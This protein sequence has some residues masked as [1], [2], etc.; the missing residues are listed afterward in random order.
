MH[1]ADRVRP[2]SLNKVISILTIVAVSAFGSF[3]VLHQSP[4]PAAESIEVPLTQ[5]LDDLERGDVKQKRA[6]MR[7]L[8]LRSHSTVEF[9]EAVRALIRAL[10]D[11]SEDVRADATSSLG[12]LVDIRSLEASATHEPPALVVSLSPEVEEALVPL[13][14]APSPKFRA[15]AA[16]SLEQLAVAARLDAPPPG[17]LDRYLSDDDTATRIAAAN[18]FVEFGRGPELLLPVVLIRT[19]EDPEVV[20]AA[21]AAIERVRL[22]PSTVPQ[23]TR[24]LAGDDARLC[25]MCASSLEHIGPAAESALTSL[26]ALI[27]KEMIAPRVDENLIRRQILSVAMSAVAKIKPDGGPLGDEALLLVCNIL[28]TAIEDDRDSY[29]LSSLNYPGWSPVESDFHLASKW[30]WPLQASV[31]LQTLKELRRPSPAAV[32]TLLEI[33]DVRV[34]EAELLRTDLAASLFVISRGTPHQGRADESLVKAWRNTN[35]A[36]H[37]LANELRRLGPEAERLI[38]EIMDWDPFEPYNPTIPTVHR[39]WKYDRPPAT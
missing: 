3:V 4:E 37:K 15:A 1:L 33:F 28:K 21:A 19:D 34:A 24:G 8:Q 31:A 12:A 20:E 14:D 22:L 10:K 35:E 7:G 17:L 18:A 25:L 38:P 32:P 6:A 13:L 9:P 29:G 2:E 39:R 26:L 27:R 5:L 36:K 16:K 23:L 30:F 11:D